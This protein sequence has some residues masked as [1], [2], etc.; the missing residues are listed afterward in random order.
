MSSNI[1]EFVTKIKGQFS[2][3]YG[4][5][6]DDWSA[7]VMAEISERFMVL[8]HSVK[9]SVTVMLTP[10][11]IKRLRSECQDYV[12]VFWCVFAREVARHEDSALDKGGRS[13]SKHCIRIYP[14]LWPSWKRFAQVMAWSSTS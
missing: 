6:M 12:D 11:E 5:E 10:T 14:R 8:N 2:A 7:M 1:K 9:K 13:G 3:K 4:I